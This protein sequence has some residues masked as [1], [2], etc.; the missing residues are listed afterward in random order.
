MRTPI[1]DF[2]R[3][4]AKSDF[5]RLHMPGHKGK[6]YLGI[7][8]LD[9]TEIK[10]A[11]NLFDACEII[12]ESEENAASLFDTGRTLYSAEGSTLAIKTMLS[13]AYDKAKDKKTAK[14]L[15]ARNVHKS[16]MFAAALLD[17]DI[18][19]MYG[20]RAHLCSCNI[21]AEDVEKAILKMAEPPFA[22][23]VTSPDYLG[24]VLDIGEIAKICN[25]Y[26]IPL[27]VDNAHGAYRAFLSESDHP[28]ARGAAMCCDSAHKTL[29][30]LTGG[31]YLHISRDADPYFLS[32]AKSR[33][34][35][36]ASTSPSYLIL[37]SLDL[38]NRYLNDGYKNKLSEC[39]SRL[40]FMKKALVS[41]GI[42]VAES[43]ELKL[44][45][46]ASDIG[47]T[48]VEL[49]E[50][51]RNFKVEPEF[52]DFEYVVLMFSTENTDED[53]LRVESALFDVQKRSPT[54]KANEFVLTEKKRIIS[55]REAVFSE[56]E[57]V[58][59]E[60]SVGRIAASPTVSCPPAV[61][62]VV[63]GEVISKEDISVFKSYGID[64]VLVVKQ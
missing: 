55:V 54:V 6:G 21:T 53:F 13:L 41:R 29:P 59:V 56:S 64:S 10:G 19:W 31:A 36:F 26:S 33:M 28:I 7:E 57:L 62:I 18:E 47:Y 46:K 49:A 25:K 61:P 37:S 2:L 45:I 32:R 24:N 20:D 27:L 35:V 15:S 4:Y 30:V 34:A 50:R 44:V 51:L 12:N 22:V 58:D 42:P 5:S 14:V 63:S 16:F 38:C 43:E 39:I 8:D 23:Y 48:G 11:D 60:A 3:S 9:I 40:D 17:F 1:Y 52:C